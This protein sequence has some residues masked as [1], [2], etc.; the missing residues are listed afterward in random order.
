[1]SFPKGFR[2]CLWTW[3]E[4]WN[5]ASGDESSVIGTR[6]VD[7]RSC[8]AVWNSV[9]K[10]NMDDE[11]SSSSAEPGGPPADPLLPV[12]RHHDIQVVEAAAES[13]SLLYTAGNALTR[14]A[15]TLIESQGMKNLVIVGHGGLAKEV[16]FLVEEINRAAAEWNLLGFIGAQRESIG[17]QQGKYVVCGDDDWLAGYGQPL[18]L[19]LA[20]GNPRLLGVLRE[21]YRANQMLAFPSLIHPRTTGD[22][23]NIRMG[24]GNVVLNAAAF[25]TDI[26]MGRF[27]IFNPGCTVAHDCALGDYNLLGPGARLAGAAVLGNRVLLG[28]GATVL[29]AVK[30]GDDV[31]VGAGAVVVESITEPG[32]YAGVPAR[33]LDR[34]AQT[35]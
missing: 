23:A 9:K 15:R 6:P 12:C 10:N 32:T 1:M 30:I 7:I 5:S 28:A 13:L 18:A 34:A 14:P 29:P 24:E 19:A 11:E 20:I 16:A 25:T 2:A 22:W 4:S 3:G 21:R 35:V 33:R 26:V 17:R 31:L 8:L 27:N